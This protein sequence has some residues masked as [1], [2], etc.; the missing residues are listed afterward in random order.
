MHIGIL[1]ANTDGSDFARRWPR[2]GEKFRA[3]LQPLRPDWSFEAI[4]VK[5]N[6]F[7]DQLDRFDGF[8]ITGSPAS[9]GAN[10]PW[11][12]KLIELIREID[13]KKRPTIG[14][15]FGHQLIGRALGGVVGKNPDGWG[16]GISP[17]H[18]AA[19]EPWMEPARKTLHL[20]AAH[21]EQLVQ[22]PA[23]AVILGG[24]GFCAIGSYKIGDHIFTTEYHPEM[25]QGFITELADEIRPLV[26]AEKAKKAKQQIAAQ[27][28]DGNIFAQWMVNFFEMKRQAVV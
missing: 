3:L 25:T 7:P 21:S 27:K 22:A 5:D 13:R 24:D 4:Q 23:G 16:F 14:I 6:V 18:F 26:G 1:V 28:A 9:A 20:Y 11:I 15:C 19:S 12:V 17:T 8:V 10:E 2:D